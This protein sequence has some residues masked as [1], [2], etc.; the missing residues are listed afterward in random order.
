M[1]TCATLVFGFF[2]FSRYCFARVSSTKR[3]Y[4]VKEKNATNPQQ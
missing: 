3:D 2:P 4:A 1:Y